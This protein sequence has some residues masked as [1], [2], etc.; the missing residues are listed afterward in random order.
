MRINRGVPLN[1]EPQNKPKKEYTAPDL[2]VYGDLREI[3]RNVQGNGRSDN[4]GFSGKTQ[5]A[6]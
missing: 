4:S 2:R 6:F 1:M 3:T 5:P